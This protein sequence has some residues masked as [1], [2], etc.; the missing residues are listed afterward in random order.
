MGKNK[1]KKFA[2]MSTFRCALQYPREVLLKEGFPYVGK[3]HEDFFGNEGGD[4]S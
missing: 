3:W 4:H 2:D 1:L